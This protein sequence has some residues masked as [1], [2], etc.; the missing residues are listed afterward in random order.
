MPVAPD[1]IV[2]LDLLFRATLTGLAAAGLGRIRSKRSRVRVAPGPLW[3]IFPRPYFGVT[4]LFVSAPLPRRQHCAAQSN[5][6]T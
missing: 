1:T 5:A 4:G 6:K 2:D 3:K